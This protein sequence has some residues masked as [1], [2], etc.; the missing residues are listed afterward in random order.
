MPGPARS[1]GS[2]G[3]GR[4]GDGPAW[5]IALK[6]LGYDRTQERMS[7]LKWVDGAESKALSPTEL[8]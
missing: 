7:A 8:L 2:I 6:A 4:R 5:L 1:S 3:S